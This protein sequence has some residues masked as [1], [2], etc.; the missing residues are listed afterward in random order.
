MAGNSINLSDDR[1]GKG[2]MASVLQKMLH[3][4]SSSCL[5]ITTMTNHIVTI[6]KT[7]NEK[8]KP[9]QQVP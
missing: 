2:K 6:G 4:A 1:V 5:F 8:L 7:M 9:D 3:F